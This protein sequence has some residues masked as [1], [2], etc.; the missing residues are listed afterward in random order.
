[1]TLIDLTNFIPTCSSGALHKGIFNK[2]DVLTDL[3]SCVLF[4]CS[5]NDVA[6]AVQVKNIPSTNLSGVCTGG[7]LF[8]V[9]KNVC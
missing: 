1:L 6:D 3:H 2:L 7:L 8:A 9:I 5:V 4:M